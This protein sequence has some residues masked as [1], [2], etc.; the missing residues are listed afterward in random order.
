MQS[1][2]GRPLDK[3]CIVCL[4]RN[5]VN[6]LFFREVQTSLRS[7]GELPGMGKNV[8]IARYHKS[9]TKNQQGC[10]LHNVFRHAGWAIANQAHFQPGKPEA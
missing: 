8:R 9:T 6:F 4:V 5:N 1:S 7:S 3:E 2:N 10:E